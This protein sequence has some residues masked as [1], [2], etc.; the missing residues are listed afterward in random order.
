[1]SRST[2]QMPQELID[3]MTEVWNAPNNSLIYKNSTGHY[4][5]I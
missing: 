5:N 4:Q 2:Q 3:M 1:M